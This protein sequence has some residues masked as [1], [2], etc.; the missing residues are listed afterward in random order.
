MRN[1]ELGRYKSRAVCLGGT[2]DSGDLDVV[3]YRARG[4]RTSAAVERRSETVA[5]Q[6]SRREL[7]AIEFVLRGIFGGID[8]V[9]QK[10]HLQFDDEL[11]CC[12]VLKC[13]IRV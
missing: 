11:V 9:W 7:M 3:L 13:L 12:V 2:G 1:S 10:L 5:V 4:R 8:G 6:C